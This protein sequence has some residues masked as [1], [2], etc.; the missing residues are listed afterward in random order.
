MVPMLRSE[1]LKRGL[2]LVLLA[3][4]A[5]AAYSAGW[6]GGPRLE[7]YVAFI[8]TSDLAHADLIQQEA[9]FAARRPRS[10]WAA[11][12]RALGARLGVHGSGAEP[13]D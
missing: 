10:G 9:V 4:V 5:Y 11:A 1:R 7:E 13:A 12:V 3:A 8:V 2:F 6:P